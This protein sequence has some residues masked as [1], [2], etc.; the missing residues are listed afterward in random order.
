M[1][2]AM[3]LKG[4]AAPKP[5]IRIAVVESDPLRFTG[6]RALFDSEPDFEL[7]SPSLPDIDAQENIDLVLLGNCYGQNLFEV[8][9][10]LKVP[11][12]Q[13]RIIVTGS[14]MDEQTILKA[15]ASALISC[16]QYGSSAKVHSG[17]HGECF[18]SSLNALA[19]RLD[20][21]FQPTKWPLRTARRKF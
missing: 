20:V 16:K 12:P 17:F 8:I 4:K 21:S 18:R 7:I 19:I 11:R 5:L 2:M 14:G 10:C 6:F 15:I 1:L 3:S 13:L 9:A